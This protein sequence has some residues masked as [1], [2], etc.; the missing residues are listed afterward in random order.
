MN[1]PGVLVAGPLR[2]ANRHVQSAL[3]CQ[4]MRVTFIPADQQPPHVLLARFE[5]LFGN[6]CNR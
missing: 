4:I 1:L 5:T 6:T 2:E 3:Y